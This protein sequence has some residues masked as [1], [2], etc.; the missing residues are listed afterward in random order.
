VKIQFKEGF[1]KGKSLCNSRIGLEI[2]YKILA[3]LE[4]I[5]L[6]TGLT[7]EEMRYLKSREDMD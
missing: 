1:L 4:V 2:A 6:E 5:E 7:I 3:L